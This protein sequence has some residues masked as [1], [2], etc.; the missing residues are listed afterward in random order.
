[1]EYFRPPDSLD[2]YNSQNWKLYKQKFDI[3]LK[4]TGKYD[5]PEDIKIAILL[6]CMGDQGLDIYN[7]FA[8]DQKSTFTKLL[9]S[10]DSYFLPKTVIHIETFKFN[11]LH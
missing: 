5:Q 8:D 7:T 10:F 9:E 1:M 6:N 4:A 11:N 2:E 3:F